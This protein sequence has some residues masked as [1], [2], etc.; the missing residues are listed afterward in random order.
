MRWPI[1]GQDD[2]DPDAFKLKLTYA[3]QPCLIFAA[4]VALA[5]GKAY[6][7]AATE[8]RSR[9]PDAVN[10]RQSQDCLDGADVMAVIT[11]WN[12]FRALTPAQ[13]GSLMAGSDC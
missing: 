11:E 7:P 4:L 2:C 6:D 8:Q 1:E 12:E 13:I 9:L 10:I 3:G 5:N